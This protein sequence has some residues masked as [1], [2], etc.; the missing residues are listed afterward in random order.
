VRT[1]VEQHVGTAQQSDDITMLALRFR[2]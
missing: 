1:R 2:G